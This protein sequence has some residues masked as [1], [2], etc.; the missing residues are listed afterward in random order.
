MSCSEVLRYGSKASLSSAEDGLTEWERQKER[1]ENVI[2][3]TPWPDLSAALSRL[4]EMEEALRVIR[5]KAGS[6]TVPA[7]PFYTKPTD[8]PGHAGVYAVAMAAL[9]GTKESAE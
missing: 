9:A 2:R 1:L 7:H 8:D 4:A 3:A 5:D 6:H